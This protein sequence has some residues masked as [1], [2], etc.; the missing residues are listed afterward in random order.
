M[1]KVVA[2]VLFTL[3]T[4]LVSSSQDLSAFDAG[5]LARANTAADADYLNDTEKKVILLMNLARFDG[6]AFLRHIADP[7]MQKLDQ[8]SS[9]TRSLRRD[10]KKVKGY[11]PLNPEKDLY[12]AALFHATES[13]KTGRIGHHNFNRRVAPLLDKYEVVGENCDYGNDDALDILMNLLIDEGVED[14][15]HRVNILKAEFAYVGVAKA[16]H[17]RYQISCV[18]LFGGKKV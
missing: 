1:K 18:Q 14:L 11:A 15:G 2:W 13:G 17:K 5:T 16:F 9:Y 7:Y 3:F 10:L 12:E 8:E 4:G 6:A